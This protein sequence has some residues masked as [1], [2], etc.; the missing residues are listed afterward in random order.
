MGGGL[1]MTVAFDVATSA[2]GF[3][4]TPDPFTFT[5]TPVGTPKGVVVTIGQGGS[6][7]D[8]IDGPVTYGG[9]AMA[10]VNTAS[11]PTEGGR[12]YL[13]FLG[14]AIPTGAQTVSIG[15]TAGSGT[16]KAACLTVTAAADTEIGVSGILET[17]QSNPQIAL[18]TVAVSSLRAN[19]IFSGLGGFVDLTAV[20]STTPY[21]GEDF[22]ANITRASYQDTAST[23][24]FSIGWT[25]AS[26]DVA[27]VAAAVQ[28]VSGVV[29]IG[30]RMALM[31]V[32]T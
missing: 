29:T 12:A 13:Y 17:D 31:G 2:A 30:S 28:E 22:G 10:R 16:K 7:L 15:H 27:M 23:G 9:V 8:Q 25:G 19:V 4:T 32:G 11:D 21:A 3:T 26:D 6:S 18:D 1:D 14:S 5:H 20:A 24:S